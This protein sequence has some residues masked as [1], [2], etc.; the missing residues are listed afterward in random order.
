MN[1]SIISRVG[2]YLE[3]AFTGAKPAFGFV[4]CAINYVIFPEKAYFMALMAV[5]AAAAMD[6][7]TKSYSI[8]K[9]N[10][11][12]KKATKNKKLFSKSL[13]TGTETKIISYLTVAI[14]TG[15]SYRVIYLKE[16]GILIAS[17]VYSVMFLREFQSNVEN[18]MDAGADLG[19]LLIFAKKK[20]K[21]IMDD[22]GIEE[23][24]TETEGSDD[25]GE[26]I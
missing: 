7:F 2:E 13:W 25:D 17:F 5:L 24:G 22:E 23:E 8:C 21:K 10:G 15:L 20:Q 3:K 11:G 26:R 6:I 16:A 9:T 18:L 14:L 4:L 19:W 12:Y 1:E